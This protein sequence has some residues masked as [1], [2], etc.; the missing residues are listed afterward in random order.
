MV[1]RTNLS[2]VSEVSARP[3]S[4]A[5][6]VRRLGGFLVLVL[7]SWL[8]ASCQKVPLLAPS[9][10]TIVLTAGT[11]AVPTN[12]S[13]DIIA[14]VLEPAGTPPHQGTHVT[15]TTTLGTIEPADAT[16]DVNGRV[17]VKFLAGN[18]N[19][20]ATITASSGGATTG[21]NGSLRIAVGSAAVG[22][23]IVNAEP[24]TVPNTGGSTTITASVLDING[25]ALSSTPVSFTTTAGSLS[26][27]LSST[28][29]NGVASTTLTTSQQATVTASVGA[30]APPS[31]TGGGTS[32]G[33]T[34]GG[35]STSAGQASGSVTVNI[36]AAPTVVI[37]PPST[38]PSVGVPVS[39]TFAV[40]VAAQNGSAVRSLTVNWGD[41]DSEQLGA[42]TGNAVAA[43]VYSATGTYRVTAT[44]VDASGN[45][46]TVSTT[47]TVVPVPRPSVIVTASPQTQFAGGTI[48]FTIQV[49]TAAGIG[50]QATSINFGDGEIRQLGGA[51]SI[52]VEKEY[53]TPGARTVTV[54]VLDTTGQTTEGTTRVSITP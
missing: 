28:N 51:T 7:G 40:T 36:S 42:V 34:G 46:N 1:T 24:A 22:R 16:T 4:S 2:P 20:T 21:T 14:H 18:A 38:P 44:V 10:S 9:G 52:T 11:N 54:T 17:I 49:T 29:T 43:H 25:N 8:V 50:V 3:H 39:F 31:G 47:V 19:G 23:V 15:F 5:A 33:G 37:T 26:G 32:G 12:T 6:G 35:T 41:G 27:V 13:A 53:A 30:Q 48:R 45:T